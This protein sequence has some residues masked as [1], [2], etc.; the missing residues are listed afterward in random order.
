MLFL[1]LRLVAVPADWW[2]R[3][4]A[5]RDG[6]DLFKQERVGCCPLQVDSEWVLLVWSLSYGCASF[7]A[8]RERLGGVKG[9]DNTI[10]SRK[11]TSRVVPYR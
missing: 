11:T 3:L 6:V 4:D 2:A 9:M 8:S 10:F 5:F 7:A 1:C